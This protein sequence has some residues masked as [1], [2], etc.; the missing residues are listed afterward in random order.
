MNNSSVKVISILFPI[1]MEIYKSG[2]M[3]D[4]IVGAWDKIEKCDYHRENK[5]FRSI[6]VTYIKDEIID[7]FIDFY[8]DKTSMINGVCKFEIENGCISKDNHKVFTFT[9]EDGEEGDYSFY[10]IISDYDKNT[11]RLEF[12][13]LD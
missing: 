1:F 13:C 6:L 2:N 10:T 5:G 4:I 12:I 11:G 9:I 8:N 3:K 7:K